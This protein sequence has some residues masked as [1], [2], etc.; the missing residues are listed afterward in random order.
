MALSPVLLLLTHLIGLNLGSL[1]AWL[2]PLIALPVLFWTLRRHD[3]P[4]AQE[5]WRIRERGGNV[6]PNIALLLVMIAIIA[7]RYMVVTDLE[8]PVWGDSLHHTMIAQLIIDQGGLFRSWEPYASMQSF[9]Y[10][11]GFHSQV[12]HGRFRTT[13][14]A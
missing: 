8:I 11:F 10:H 13:R 6:W 9:T 12:S 4:I 7:V 5:A 3:Q 14:M 1:Y 2:P